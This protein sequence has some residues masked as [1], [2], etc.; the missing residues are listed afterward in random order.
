MGQII[1]R[2]SLADWDGFLGRLVSR[3]QEL[4]E[5]RFSSI[6]LRLT[7]M[8]PAVRALGPRRLS[9]DP[10]AKVLGTWDTRWPDCVGRMPSSSL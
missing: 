10:A 7:T 1:V 2:A 8:F 9:S 5:G 4:E 3:G 6:S